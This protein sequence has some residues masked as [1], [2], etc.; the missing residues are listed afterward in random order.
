[1]LKL[2]DRQH[3]AQFRE[4]LEGLSLSEFVHS[5]RPTLPFENAWPRFQSLRDRLNRLPVELRGAYRLLL[6]GEEVPV[7]ETGPLLGAPLLRG[8][9][10]TG[11]LVSERE[12]VVRT[13][14][15]VVVPYGGYYF[16]ADVPPKY[17]TRQKIRP[18]A[19]VDSDSLF[20]ARM[21]PGVPKRRAVDLCT[22]A[23]ALAIVASASAGEIVATDVNP[24]ALNAAR[25]NAILN[26]VDQK[27]TFSEC[28]LFDAVEPEPAQLVCANPPY[29]ALPEGCGRFLAGDGGEDG[30]RVVFSL[31]NDLDA[32]LAPDGHALFLGG[33]YGDRQVPATPEEFRQ[34]A[35]ER[36]LQVDMFLLERLTV[37]S[38]G[39]A[40]ADNFD[41]PEPVLNKILN[42][43]SERGFTHFYVMLF[44]ARRAPAGGGLRLFDGLISMPERAKELRQARR[45]GREGTPD[46]GGA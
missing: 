33:T 44:R 37:Q 1:V 43:A 20:L 23:G 26:G 5:I 45:D 30:L 39:R 22:G 6:L 12:G 28:S 31:L 34:L 10:E 25:F 42:H 2:T 4:L 36:R 40:A 9:E 32:H 46:S 18:D 3:I 27:I 7:A 17:P 29:L 16:V 35:S 19:Y 15:Y 14:G 11:L 13:R 8:L 38:Y 41:A 24:I 21:L